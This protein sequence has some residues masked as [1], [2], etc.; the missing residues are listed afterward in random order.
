MGWHGPY[1]EK[2]FIKYN[3]FYKQWI[4][5]KIKYSQK[6]FAIYLYLNRPKICWS[7][8]LHVLHVWFLMFETHVIGS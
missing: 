4:Q 6:L 3:I 2:I 8:R 7:E 5:D 1:G